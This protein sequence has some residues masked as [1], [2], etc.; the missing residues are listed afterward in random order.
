MNRLTRWVLFTL[1]FLSGFSGLVYQVVWTRMA[2]A[3]FG[4]ITP[5][6]SVVISV[7][8]LGL[9][10]GSWAGG[11]A[12]GPL[13]RW[14]GLS[15]AAFYGLAELLIGCGAFAVPALFAAG[16]RALLGSGQ[17][18]SAGYLFRSAVVLAG[19]I[20]PWCVCMGATFPFMLAHVRERTG[21]TGRD[22][23]GGFSFLYVANVLGAMAGTALT[24]LVLVEMLGFRHTLW[25]AAA[26]NGVIAVVAAG[27]GAT[28][29]RDA[30]E[31]A[32]LSSDEPGGATARVAAGPASDRFVRAVLF[33]TGFVSMAMEVVWCRGFAVV[34]K[35]QVYSF[36]MILFAYLAATFAGSAAYRWVARRGWCGGRG[37]RATL[38]LAIAVA[39][40]LPALANDVRVTA[41]NFDT[42]VI[43]PRSAAIILLSICPLCGLL[44]YL[45]P[46]LIDDY[47]SGQPGRAGTAYAANVVGCILGPLVACYGLMPYVSGRIALVLLSL[48]L[49]ACWAAE[50]WRL[51]SARVAR[52]GLIV[53]TT[54]AVALLVPRDFEEHVGDI[55]PHVQVRRDAIASVAAFGNEGFQRWLIV[56]GI[57]MTKLTPITKFISH[58]PLALHRGPPRSALV[59]CFGM[60]TSYRSALSWGIDTTVVE[61][62]PS[63]PRMFGQYFDDADRRLADPHA[64]VVIDDGRRYLSRCGRSFDMITVDPPPPAEAAGSSLLFS[65]DFYA[66]AK[67][68]LNP[69]G[70]V[71]MWSPS[72]DPSTCRAV[73]RSMATSFPHVRCF[74]SVEDWGTHLLGSMSPIPTL[75][76]EQAAAAMPPAA[77][78]DLLEWHPRG[79]LAGYV[80]QVLARERPVADLMGGDPSVV[81]TDDRPFNEYFLVR[82]WRE[83]TVPR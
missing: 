56:N 2:F 63:V 15:A 43:D 1:F 65:S 69:D 8:M 53:G 13:A 30:A 73:V 49:V 54:L 5:V 31:P 62:V 50:A 36:A 66:L 29:R 55:A 44:G 75:T 79:T 59:I 60:G 27:L 45:T 6:L 51:G 46:S 48:P 38:F 57:G 33:A 32:V 40:L 71:Q 39:A 11:R 47:S 61:L 20:L 34:L 82:R 28:V 24:A 19:S 17:I 78:A 25:V 16:S 10:V 64:H 67:R 3:S 37:R 58:L 77:A 72:G 4:I 52:G 21:G 35:T 81:V 14:T 80:G 42:E 12:I 74:A 18:D 76:A 41:Q 70:I 68:H 26:G 23:T 7:F 22:G 83:R 9:A